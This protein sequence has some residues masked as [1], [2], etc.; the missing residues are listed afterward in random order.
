MPFI[1]LNKLLEV[2]EMIIAVAY[3]QGEIF[4]HFGHTEQFKLYTVD[5]EKVI[6]SEIVETNGS[7][8]G[9]LAGFLKAHQ[10]EVLI[11]GGIGGGA[12]NAL[13]EAEIKL[14]GG[15]SGKADEAVEQ[16]LNQSLNYNPEVHCTHHDGEHG[17]SHDCHTHN[18][19]ECG[20]HCHV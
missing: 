13:N 3:N 14:Y 7:G 12:K 11:C 5:G 9:A 2:I 4:Q 1:I 15:V 8:H 19:H 18:S 10:V 17:K 16:L 6:S 20:H